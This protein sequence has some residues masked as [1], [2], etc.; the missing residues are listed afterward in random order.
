MSDSHRLVLPGNGRVAVIGAGPAGMATALSVRQ[1]G[2]EVKVFERYREAR[3]AGNILNL[4]PPPL[5]ALRAM[6][7]DTD[8]LGA[9]C[10]VQFR[11]LRGK[12]R[13]DVKLAPEVQEEYHGSFIGL[14]RPD[15]Y[16]RM[17]AAV[18]PGVLQFNR[19]V[20][21]FTQGED[22]VTVAFE[23]GTTENFDVLIGADGIDSL[24]RRT[25]WGDAPK[26]EH[27]LHIFGGYTFGSP[28][29][30]QPGEAVIGH[31]RTVQGSWTA[32]RSKG[33][34][35]FQWWVL[36]ATDP[37]APA[38]AD[39]HAAAT[40]L[41]AGFPD[42]LPQLIAETDPRHVQ[43]WVLRDRPALKQWSKGRVTLVGDAAHPTSPYAAYGA[44]MA[45]EDGF[46]VGRALR[47]V[48]LGDSTAVRSALQRYEDPRKPYTAQ[49]VKLAWMNGKIFHHTP[50]PLR[51]IR[52]L[53][54][55]HTPF[56]QKVVGDASPGEIMKQLALIAEQI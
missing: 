13:V 17:L 40:R 2:H 12:V 10:R 30:E 50:A 19:H 26:R 16:E 37:D 41:G 8:D 39:A 46:F 28:P 32:I 14:L 45:I 56:L 7:V 53:V 15:L 33:R 31:S 48:D 38:P 20:T 47:G 55:D 35:G 11:N 18:P 6:G 52:D 34:D 1:G 27:R 4:W 21:G 3:P 36:E 43:R 42:P 29:G 51:P 54:M 9:P 49:Q 5:R 44:G 24:V 25:L 22:G 23:D